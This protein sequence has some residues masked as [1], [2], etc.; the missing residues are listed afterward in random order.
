MYNFLTAIKE[1]ARLELYQAPWVE[2][3][4]FAIQLL[5]V[6]EVYIQE[7]LVYCVKLL[8]SVLH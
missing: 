1:A 6:L 8:H 3:F 2:P 5:Q 4:M 7:L